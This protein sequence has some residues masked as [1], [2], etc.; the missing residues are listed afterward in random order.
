MDIAHT[1][2]N[3]A[4]VDGVAAA[5]AFLAGYVARVPGYRHDG[6]WDAADLFG[7]TAFTGV[8]ALNAF[9]ADLDLDTLHRRADR[10]AVSLA[11]VI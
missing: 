10:Y 4:F 3:L 1:R 6:W 11:A 7:F 2:A 8:L 5:D 9:G